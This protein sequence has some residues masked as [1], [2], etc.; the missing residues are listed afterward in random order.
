MKRGWLACIAIMWLG[1][2]VT[3]TPPAPPPSSPPVEEASPPTSDKDEPSSFSQCLAGASCVPTSQCDGAATNVSCGVGKKCCNPV[4]C[5]GSCVPF[6][7]WCT[8]GNQTIDGSAVCPSSG[9]CCV[10][11]GVE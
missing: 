10:T 4:G 2:G 11:F 3:E 7:S 9:F 5:A 8:A 6:R 1:C